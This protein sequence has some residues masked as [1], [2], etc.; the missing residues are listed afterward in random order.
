VYVRGADGCTCVGRL[1]GVGKHVKKNDERYVTRG[2][3]G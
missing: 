2:V 3:T 1:R